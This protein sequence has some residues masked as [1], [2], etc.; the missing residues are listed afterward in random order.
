MKEF[1]RRDFVKLAGLAGVGLAAAGAAP[2]A[3][4][5]GLS[6]PDKILRRTRLMMGTYVTMT[7]IDPSL[8]KAE[9]A[10]AQALAEMERLERI[11]SRYRDDGPLAHLAKTGTL[12]HPAP[13]LTQVLSV[14]A[15]FHQASAGRFDISIAPVVDA[16][17]E[18]FAKHGR[19]LSREELAPLLEL[20]DGGAVEVGPK[21]IR[22]LK[23]GMALSLDGLGKGFI[24][25]LAAACLKKAG[26]G[27]ALINAG[28]DI[29]A[30]GDKGGRPWRVGVIDPTAPGGKGPVIKLKDGAVATSGNYEVFFDQEKLHH[31]I[32]D[33]GQGLSPTGPVSISVKAR[34]CLAADAL[35]TTIFCLEAKEALPF[36][37]AHQAQGLI[38]NRRG[39]RISRGRWG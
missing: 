36:L 19:P 28:G 25:D 4:A 16:T 3:L 37:A 29:Y 21:R 30:L 23:E 18:T 33:P 5:R 20:V 13:E 38:V 10:Y 34:T 15:G 14:A 17:R 35:S 26:I 39:E 1:S 22:L 24:V 7:I 32:V 31:H 9:E 2:Q 8:D 27:R 12:N 11:L 6:G